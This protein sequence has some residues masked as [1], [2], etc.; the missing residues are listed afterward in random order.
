MQPATLTKLDAPDDK[1]ITLVAGTELRLGRHSS[2]SLVLED[3]HC[4]RHH[5]KI[6]ERGKRWV[7]YDLKSQNGSWVDGKRVQRAELKNGQEIQFGNLRFRFSQPQS[8]NELPA[9]RQA[10]ELDE[11][12]TPEPDSAI[13]LLDETA[14]HTD[15]LTALCRFMA[16][17]T[18]EA[19]SHRLVRRALDVVLANTGASV[20]GFLSLDQEG[21]T[22]PRVVLPAGSDVDRHLS[23]SLTEAV[24][25]HGRVIWLTNE[26][27]EIDSP[28]L[29][30]LT[31]AICV[32][33]PLQDRWL[34]ALHAYRM[35]GRFNELA[36]QFCEVVARHLAERLRHL[37]KSKSLQAENTRLRSQE[38]LADRIVGRSTAIKKLNEEIALAAPHNATALL[39][40][41]TGVGKELVARA[42]HLQSPRR[43]EPFVV[44]NCAAMPRELMESLLFGHRKGAFTGAH[45]SRDGAF[46]QADGGTLFLDEVGELTPESAAKLLRVLEDGMVQPIGSDRLIQVNVRV[47]AATH[48]DL[49]Q[50]IAKGSFRRD[51]FYRLRQIEITIPPLRS[52][53]EDIPDL[54]DY[55]LDELDQKHGRRGR[56]TPQAMNRFMEH[57]WPGNVREL[58]NTLQRAVLMSRTGVIDVGDLQ[59]GVESKPGGLPTLKLDDLIR[60]AYEEAARRTGQNVQEMRK[61]LGVSRATIYSKLREYGWTMERN[62]DEEEEA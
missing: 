26:P 14:F 11:V 28:S 62:K 21:K 25:K 17:A 22:V 6:S 52:H 61:L 60:L 9:V 49:E 15:Q 39:R 24:Q 19:D 50:M 12:P 45:E 1:P 27:E 54:V 53:P 36:A 5:A 29:L 58:V 57:S 8:E 51:L 35:Q 32:P 46:R 3:E 7:L 44:A 59:L 47:I 56:L 37:R 41:E 40:G 43:E 42:L 33:M 13:A 18:N 31:D 30:N 23:K 34:G 48:R 38:L 16:E 4:S 10:A 55:Y 20:V 2:N